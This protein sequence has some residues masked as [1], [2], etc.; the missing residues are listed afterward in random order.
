MGWKE[1]DGER[2]VLRCGVIARGSCGGE[3]YLGVL[4]ILRLGRTSVRRSAATK[5]VIS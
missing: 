1:P 3:V 5:H 2:A 4:K